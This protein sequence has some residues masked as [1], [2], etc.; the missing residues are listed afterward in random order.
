MK[1]A[2]H[3]RM[4]SASAA[5]LA[6][7]ALEGASCT[8]PTE[9]QD[10]LRD[11]PIWDELSP[12]RILEDSE[13]GTL[14]YPG[15]KEKA[16]FGSRIIFRVDQ[17]PHIRAYFEGDDLLLGS[18][19]KDYAGVDTLTVRANNAQQRLV[20]MT[21]NVTDPSSWLRLE[22]KTV[23]DPSAG[24]IV[25]AGL[26]SM[27][28][29]P[30]HGRAI[31]VIRSSPSYEIFYERPDLRIRNIAQQYAG[32]DSCI[33]SG[34]G[35]RAGFLL[36]VS[37]TPHIPTVTLAKTI[38]VP[39]NYEIGHVLTTGQFLIINAWNDDNFFRDKAYVYDKGS[40]TLVAEQTE[41]FGRT[42]WHVAET[43]SALY[44]ISTWGGCNSSVAKRSKADFALEKR[45]SGDFNAGAIVSQGER[46]AMA[47]ADQLYFM[48]ADQVSGPF[49]IPDTGNFHDL[50]ALNGIYV[51]GTRNGDRAGV[52]ALQSNLQPFF[53]DTVEGH[54]PLEG[55]VAYAAGSRIL[56]RSETNTKL[57]DGSFHI[58]RQDTFPTIQSA[59]MGESYIYINT[60]E[61]TG[62][63]YDTDLNRLTSVPLD[64]DDEDT[65]GFCGGLFYGAK[66][67]TLYLYS[68][69]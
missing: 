60:A 49:T 44:L 11:A 15:I 35:K 10:P 34:N 54:A 36:T 41:Q 16:H 62:S 26:E 3:L 42:V 65:I 33:V 24:A 4:K 53:Q 17:N 22:D 6:F 7:L 2:S 8:L 23:N 29:S 55:H 59:T 57:Y 67:N 48:D 61:D 9:P 63:L 46:L 51:T 66:A 58:L 5:L 64:F 38:T 12:R 30:D 47:C 56:L 1:I 69:R 50:T 21:E 52:V 19:Q 37:K 20:I 28:Y 43:S 40:F 14:L 32:T 45:I 27:L 68:I 18:L 31:T 39:D 25:Y 13:P